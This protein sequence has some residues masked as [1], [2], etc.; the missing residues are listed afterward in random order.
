MKLINFQGQFFK[1][2]PIFQGICVGLVFAALLASC[3]PPAGSD[4][5]PP[6]ERQRDLVQDG[7]AEARQSR[8]DAPKTKPA[9]SAAP[10]PP[11]DYAARDAATLPPPGQP[12]VAG[13]VSATTQS[14]GAERGMWVWHFECYGD[15]RERNRLLDFSKEHGITRLLVQMHYEADRSSPDPANSVAIRAPDALGDLV[16]CAG[17]AG[18]LVEALEGD[19]NW[20]LLSQQGEFWPKFN[21][22]LAW[23][24]RQPASRKLAG[25]HL[26]IEP[27]IL[28]QF[29]SDEKPRVMRDYLDLLAEVGRRL[30]A[31]NT[32]MTLAADIPFWYDTREEMDPD[33][34][35]LEYNGKKQ[36]LSR[37][38]QDLCDY[39]A[40]MSYRQNAVGGNSIT[41]T[42]EGEVAYA[43]SIGKKAF[44][45]VEMTEVSDTPTISFYGT[46]PSM[47][48]EQLRQVFD[49]MKDHKGFGGVLIHHYKSYRTYLESSPSGGPS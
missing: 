31:E 48:R 13:A 44:P 25:I 30:K 15:E 43:G 34:H 24:A 20:A 39:V 32:P 7:V 11:V 17:R 4:S 8:H 33:N 5:R 29:K 10:A 27:Y 18:I 47:F 3:K 16:E 14:R 45:S 23:N 19:P 42:S 40:V 26:D 36:Y 2:T 37:H 21:A 49:E 35:I 9:E 12:S 46:D 38:V 28:K 6:R 22:I 41:S 1:K